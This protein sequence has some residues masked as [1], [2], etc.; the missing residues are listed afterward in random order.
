MTT[1]VVLPSG[2]QGLVEYKCPCKAAKKNLTPEKAAV[3]YR[4]FCSVLNISGQLEL[5]KTHASFY[6]VQAF[7]SNYSKRV[8]PLC[9]LDTKRP[10]LTHESFILYTKFN[11]SL[12]TSLRL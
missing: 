3:K 11:T 7:P 5:R 6:Q 4:D 10:T 9:D 8:V 1:F 2:E 12:A